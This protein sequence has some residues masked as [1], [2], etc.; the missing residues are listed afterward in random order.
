MLFIEAEMFAGF[1]GWVLDQQFM[2]Q[3][4]SPYLLAHG[5]AQPVADATTAVTFPRAGQYRVWVRTMDWV[6]PWYASPR[7]ADAPGRFQL[8]VN[9][10]P[11]PALFGTEGADWHWQDGGLVQ[12]PAGA[13]QLALHD[14]AGCEGRC[15]AILFSDEVA[16]V[17]PNDG[18]ELAAF[19]RRLLGLPGTPDD[20]GCFD[21]VVAG[22]GI[23]GMCAA[24]AA[25]RQGLAVALV[26]DRFIP[27]G[28]NSSE[29]L[30]NA[31]GK[32]CLEPFPHVGELVKEI[33]APKGIVPAS[34]WNSPTAEDARKLALLLAEPRLTQFS[35][36][37]VVAVDK[38]GDAVVAIVVQDIRTARQMRLAGSYFADCTGDGSL[39]FLAGADHDMFRTSHMGPTNGWRVV[40]TQAPAPFPR[41]LWAIDL[42]DKPF[43]G[44]GDHVGQWGKPGLGSLGLWFWES[45][46]DLDPILE[47]ERI[48]DTNLRAMYGAW[49]ALKNT[50]ALYPDHRLHWA[51]YLAGKRE[52]RRLFGD[53]VITRGDL[54][55]QRQFPD[56]CVPCT[57]HMDLHV[58]HRDFQKG[59]E[60]EEFISWC[61]V[62]PFPAPFWLPYRALYSRS[63]TNLFM[64]GRDIS[65]TH[66]ALGG[67]R[68]QC[69]TGMMGEV[70][71]AAASLCV[72]H[73]A[74][75]RQLYAS[76][77]PALLSL[78]HRGVRDAG[79]TA[80]AV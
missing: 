48:R 21:L 36:Q 49:D 31:D 18:A 29:I 51:A 78:L 65:V 40:E 58:P 5:L 24:V 62:A 45:G 77:L 37:R 79:T 61:N 10:L 25:A 11:L 39:G 38:A 2:D 73:Q 12:V 22:A 6:A 23:A 14:L 70:V 28:A 57:W 26:Y 8:L 30:V 16:F 41:C 20:G 72:K 74:T 13:C 43:P 15:D 59:F 69:T 64:A 7:A 54:F 27:G 42:Q 44:R 63:V 66:E 60:G 50:D 3:M 46:F 71:G 53:V 4:G 47:A 68:V 33:A 52:S 56:A 80:A 55:R 35:G 76:H 34:D 32:T 1:G 19:R 67:V 75:P 17:P 9:G